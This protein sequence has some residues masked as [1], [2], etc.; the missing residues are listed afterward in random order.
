M[1]TTPEQVQNCRHCGFWQI[2]RDEDGVCRRRAPEATSRAEEIAHWPQTYGRQGCGDGVPAQE[3]TFVKCSDCV[4]WRRYKGGLH[5]MNRADM[6]NSWWAHAGLCM[7]HAPRP[8]IEPGPRSFW[9]ATAESDGCGEGVGAEREG[10][11]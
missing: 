4:F 1:T 3:Q 6:P 11:T 5:P 7:R 8:M 2:V 10:A 9:R